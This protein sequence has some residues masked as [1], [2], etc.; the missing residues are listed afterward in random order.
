MKCH[1]PKLNTM[2]QKKKY[3]AVG[4]WLCGSTLPIFK[5]AFVYSQGSMRMGTTVKPYGKG[6]YDIDLILHLPS[7]KSHHSPD[8][9]RELVGQR[10]SENGKYKPI[11]KELNRGWCLNYAGDFI[12]T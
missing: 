5:D 11:L 7:G 3:T 10:L 2:K 1:Y 9:I 4:K 8:K 6:E 12:W